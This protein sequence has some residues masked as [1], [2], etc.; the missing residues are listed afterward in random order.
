[1]LL[2]VGPRLPG[3]TTSG[4][5]TTA[6]RRAA[7]TPI[8]ATAALRHRRRAVGRRRPGRPRAPHPPGPLP[9]RAR[10]PDGA[11]RGRRRPTTGRCPARRTW[12]PRRRRSGCRSEQ[13]REAGLDA[14]ECVAPFPKT[15][16]GYSVEAETGPRDDRRRPRDAAAGR[17]GDGLPGRVRGD[18][19]VRARDQGPRDGRRPGRDDPRVP[20]DVADLQRAVRGGAGDARR[21]IGAG[22][23]RAASRALR[24]ARD[25]LPVHEDQPRP[26]VPQRA[27]D[28]DRL[29]ERGRRQH[30]DVRAMA[31]DQPPAVPL[32]G[33]DAP[34]RRTRARS[35]RH[36]AIALLRARAARR[37]PA[38]TARPG[39]RRTR[40][41]GHGSIG[42]TG[43]SVPNGIT[44]PRGGERPE[45]VGPGVGAVAPQPARL[46]GVA[47]DVDGLHRGGD[48]ERGEPRHVVAASM[49][50]VCS[51]RG[52]E[53]RRARRSGRGRRARP[54]PPRRRCRGSRSRSRAA[55]ARVA[56][57]RRTSGGV[58]PD[59]V[60]AVRRLGLARAT[61]RAARA[62]PPS[63]TRASRRRTS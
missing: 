38:T 36:S 62:G 63:A 49:S 23:P 39:S 17:G 21:R 46:L 29:G 53:R 52:I 11:G 13:A 12:T 42:S 14:F 9:G 33:A 5:S 28:L 50:C 43:A 3:R 51:T 27:A 19:R 6:S 34:G 1:M 25:D 59:A 24:R 48:A 18:P 20:V 2:A 45:R 31:R 10:R 16:K 60:P 61:A 8:R 15:S 40:R 4:S 44:R 26:G 47:A 58:E 37:P 7:R 57:A 30:D 54:G 35:E 22:R 55:A 56:C 41:P 32:P